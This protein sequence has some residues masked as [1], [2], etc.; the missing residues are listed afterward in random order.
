MPFSVIQSYGPWDYGVQTTDPLKPYL[1]V[2]AGGGLTP[3]VNTGLTVIDG[4]NM[5]NLSLVAQ[6]GTW[7]GATIVS[8]SY[9]WIVDGVDESGAV[10]RSWVAGNPGRQNASITV[11]ETVTDVNGLTASATS[12]PMVMSGYAYSDGFSV[13]TDTLLQNYVSPEGYTW[14]KVTAV[15]PEGII[16]AANDSIESNSPS[17][18]CIYRMAAIPD[19]MAAG[20]SYRV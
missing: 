2:Q 1:T 4:S 17:A 13:S 11:R 8:R 10:A 16:S 14:V 6:N 7:S 20:G 19:G 12:D 18:S 3:P 5:P 9:Q 15:T